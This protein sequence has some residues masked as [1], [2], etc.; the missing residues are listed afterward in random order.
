MFPT[1]ATRIKVFIFAS[2]S[3][4]WTNHF[5]LQ[6]LSMQKKFNENL[7]LKTPPVFTPLLS[8]L[9]ILF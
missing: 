3:I 5:I 7:S 9:L 6:I 1:F 4:T 2:E 8:N